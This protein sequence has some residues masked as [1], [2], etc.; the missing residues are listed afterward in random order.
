MRLSAK[1]QTRSWTLQYR[2]RI[3]IV[4]AR[5]SSAALDVDQSLRHHGI[6]KPTG[7]RCQP[8]RPGRQDFAGASGQ[9]TVAALDAGPVEPA[10]DTKDPIS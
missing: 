2:I 8:L 4:D 10:L 6:A 3:R 5:R 7:E 1:P 9:D